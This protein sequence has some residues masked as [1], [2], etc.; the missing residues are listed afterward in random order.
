M[1]RR[2]LAAFAAVAAAAT[3]A[4][5][6]AATGTSHRPQIRDG[7][8]DWAVPS[9]D[10]LDGTVTANAKSITTTV[11]LAAAPV[12]GLVT[13]YTLSF[14][15]GCTSYV[16]QYRWT[17]A[18]PADSVA[19]SQYACPAASSTPVPPPAQPVATYPATATVTG[20]TIR[21]SFAPAAKLRP[22][23][24]VWAG[25]IADTAAEVGFDGNPDKGV[26]GGDIA[27]SNLFVLGK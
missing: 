22:G 23:A 9:Q 4:P 17:G 14:V 18:A 12:P 21:F 8:G 19:M 20:T 10:I 11:R 5:A 25:V 6:A 26:V 15:V 13:Y 2:V 27:F 3:C 16:T 7:A 1:R 24:K